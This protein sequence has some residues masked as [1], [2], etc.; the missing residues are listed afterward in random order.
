MPDSPPARWPALFSIEQL[1]E[2]VSVSTRTCEKW[3]TMGLLPAPVKLPGRERL[4]R[5]RRE[6]IDAFLAS[7]PAGVES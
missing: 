2:Y 1:A 3:K 7:L 6:E 5:F 4:I